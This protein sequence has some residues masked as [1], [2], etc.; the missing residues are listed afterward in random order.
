MLDNATGRAF[1][2]T[3]QIPCCFDID[4]V[5]IRELLSLELA[6]GRK[7]ERLT[8]SPSIQSRF[9]MRILSIAKIGNLLEIHKQ[10]WRERTRRG[11]GPESRKMLGD[12]CIV[13]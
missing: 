5:V 3:Y 7:A 9:L 11:R 2:F 8:A 10:I 13:A 4:D 6:C 1:E 12:L